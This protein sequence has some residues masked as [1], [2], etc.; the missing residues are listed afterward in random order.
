MFILMPSHSS[1]CSCWKPHGSAWHLSWRSCG[2]GTR[3][4][5]A[6]GVERVVVW[7]KEQRNAS[8]TRSYWSS[9]NH[10]LLASACTIAHILYKDSVGFHYALGETI[11]C[12]LE[13]NCTDA[14]W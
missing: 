14:M 3:G 10:H 12:V 1:V 9:W 2:L 7:G 13:L 4:A 8:C 6:P 5:F 11:G